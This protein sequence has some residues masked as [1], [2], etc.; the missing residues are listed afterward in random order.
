[1]PFSFFV[2]MISMND[3]DMFFIVVHG[4]MLLRRLISK[5]VCL[6]FLFTI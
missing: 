1:M 6:Q 5:F 2:D 3:M 4:K